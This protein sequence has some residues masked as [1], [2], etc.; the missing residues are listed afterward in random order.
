MRERERMRERKRKRER[1][2]MRERTKKSCC[3]K[4]RINRNISIR[5]D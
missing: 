2:G 4:I 1:E 5:M 3:L